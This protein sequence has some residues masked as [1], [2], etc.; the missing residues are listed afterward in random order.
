M[1]F[2]DEYLFLT[3]PTMQIIDYIMDK[4]PELNKKGLL[5]NITYLNNYWKYKEFS[6][7][8]DQILRK[9]FF[10]NKSNDINRLKLLCC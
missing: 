2:Y 10:N 3:I 8:R 4:N 7:K 5:E 6:P 9:L 1:N